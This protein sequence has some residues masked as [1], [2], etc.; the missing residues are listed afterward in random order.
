[1]SST[2]WF[3]TMTL[4]VVQVSGVLFGLLRRGNCYLLQVLPSL[5]DV[6]T[7]MVE[8]EIDP[9]FRLLVVPSCTRTCEV[10]LQDLVV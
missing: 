6:A 1:M 10:E 8:A 9:L 7:D 3:W 2:Y 5:F 4:I